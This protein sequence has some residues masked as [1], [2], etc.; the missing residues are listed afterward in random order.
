MTEVQQHTLGF[1]RWQG[2]VGKT[3]KIPELYSTGTRA[4]NLSSTPVSGRRMLIPPLGRTSVSGL[5]EIP[6][7]DP[8]FVPD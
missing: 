8:A 5:T 4:S 7:P 6:I 1:G 2:K 3:R